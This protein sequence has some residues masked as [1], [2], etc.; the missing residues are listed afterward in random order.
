MTLTIER[1]RQLF[2]LIL[3][4]VQPGTSPLRFRAPQNR[5]LKGLVPPADVE[6]EIGADVH[7]P[8]HADPLGVCDCNRGVLTAIPDAPTRLP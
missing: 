7:S 8:G 6:C 1:L 4:P 5:F 3:G 2:A